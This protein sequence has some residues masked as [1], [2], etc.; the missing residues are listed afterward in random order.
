MNPN[1]TE[2]RI[3]IAEECGWTQIH[4]ANTLAMGGIWKGYPP[5][6]PIIGQPE[7]LPDYFNDLNACVEFEATLDTNV[8]EGGSPRYAYAR[9]LYALTPEDE[10]PFRANSKTRCEAFLRVR[11]PHLF[12]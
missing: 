6:S 10:Q 11:R 8:M 9:E 7:L 12:L 3:A 2:M 5:K 1:P 4:N